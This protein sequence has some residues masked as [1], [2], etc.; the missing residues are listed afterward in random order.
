MALV[1]PWEE[2]ALG[3]GTIHC[4]REELATLVNSSAPRAIFSSVVRVNAKVGVRSEETKIKS[5]VE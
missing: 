2:T 1:L 4:N 5:K 3:G